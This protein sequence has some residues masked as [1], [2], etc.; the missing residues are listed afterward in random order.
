MGHPEKGCIVAPGVAEFH[1]RHGLPASDIIAPNRLAAEEQAQ[2]EA[3]EQARREAE[4]SAK[5]EAQQKAEREAA[6][7]AKREAA[8]QAKREAAEKDKVSNQQDGD[9][10]VNPHPQEN[11][12][13]KRVRGAQCVS[14]GSGSASRQE[15]SR[16][17]Q[18]M[19]V[20]NRRYTT[21]YN[22]V[23]GKKFFARQVIVN[24]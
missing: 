2:R 16:H 6:E 14:S 7:Q 20:S 13:E 9:C 18:A 19:M 17:V 4:E 23:C 15:C 8:E 12:V 5:R 1:V 24:D 10:N 3:E 11:V 21:R 22:F